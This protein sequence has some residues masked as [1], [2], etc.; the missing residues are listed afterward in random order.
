MS[1]VAVPET[2]PRSTA[3]VPFRLLWLLSRPGTSSRAVSVLPIVAFGL[4]TALLLG[5]LGG[6]QSF[7]SWDDD[8]GGMYR[9]LSGIAVA[10]LAVPLLSVG[11]SAA[12]LSARRRDDRLS[13]LRLLGATPA[14]VSTM[15]VVESTL[16][17]LAGALV[18]V[19]GYL[20]MMPALGLIQFR[21][22]PLGAGSLWLGVPA[23]ATVVAGVVVLAAVSAALGLR[24]VVI[25]PLGVRTRQT[26]PKAHWARILVGLAVIGLVSLSMGMLGA[27]P[28][29]GVVTGILLAGSAA[30]LAVLNVVG[31]FAISVAAR[32]QLRKASNPQRLMAARS[33]LESP[34]AAWRQASGVAMTSFVAVF[35]GTGVAIADTAGSGFSPSSPEYYLMDDIRTGV[36][37]TV[38][39]SFLMV[40]CS[41]GINQAAA[42]LDRTDLYVNLDRLGM[43]EAVMNAAR[44]RSVMSPLLLVGIGS[45]LCAAVV[46][47]P[48]TGIAILVAPL[49]LLVISGS[50]AVGILLV[51]LAL[52]VTTPVLRRVLAG[53]Q[54]AAS[55]AAA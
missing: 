21:G 10:L 32:R 53:G 49:S 34:K 24:K 52:M 4:V 36:L 28:G 43:P 17:A 40:A 48:L 13:T 12:R 51:W 44:I 47:F 30:A 39:A 22:E 26:A 50:L 14:V 46:I 7:W 33:V 1:G 42:V 2:P 3:A 37:I 54:S 5:V 31:P 35:G 9:I 20:A 16:L 8:L 29:M 27:A 45:A 6:A 41:A 15:T 23:I 38:L 18:G 55:P 11:G 19:I 25:S